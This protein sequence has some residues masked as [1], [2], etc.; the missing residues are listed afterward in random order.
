MYVRKS[1]VILLKSKENK[2]IFALFSAFLI[3]CIFQIETVISAVKRGLAICSVSIIPSLF[4]FLILSDII[5]TLL[6]QENT[7]PLPPKA[8]L[9]SIGSLCGFPVGAVACDKL[10]R[11]GVI[12]KSDAVKII[13]LC[14][15][16]SPAFVIGAVGVSML[17]SKP[18]G[19]LI[20]FSQLIAS[21]ILLL[22]LKI[23]KVKYNRQIS[24][25]RFGDIFFSSVEKTITSILKICA[26]IC[27]F[28]VV[29]SVADIYAEDIYALLLSVIAE[30][31]CGSISAAA[32]FS[33][34]PILSVSLCGFACGFSGICV[35]M[36]ILSVLQSVKLKY[37]QLALC[38]AAQGILTAA[39]SAVGYYLFFT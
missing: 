20:Y 2:A 15:N 35:H 10:L 33:A 27:F 4:L 14:N 18:L 12:E 31:G 34:S 3:I 38:K 6:L 32:Y 25:K 28:N 24:S 16:A 30:I 11:N 36:Q 17:K 29:L 13:P 26:L 22:P 9:F 39:L 19:V 23:S 7:L 5:V 1:E 37:F 8:I 21:L